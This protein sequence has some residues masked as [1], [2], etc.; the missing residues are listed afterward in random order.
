MMMFPAE[1]SQTPEAPGEAPPVQLPVLADGL[2]TLRRSTPV[3]WGTAESLCLNVTI[4]ILGF[5]R[6]RMIEM[7]SVVS[8]WRLQELVDAEVSF[9]MTSACFLLIL[10]GYPLED[11]YLCGYSMEYP[12]LSLDILWNIH[13][14]LWISSRISISL[15]GYPL[16][17]PY[18][19]VDIL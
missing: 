12:Y 16:E 13:I 18:L 5:V 3:C 11:P 7:K 1:I 15:C 9:I 14:S 10:I 17:Y 2:S 8:A 6:T 4:V 19:S